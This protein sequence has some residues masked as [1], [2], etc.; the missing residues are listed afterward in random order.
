MLLHE[1]VQSVASKDDLAGFVRALRID[2]EQN[3]AQWEN[4]SL[5]SFLS[6]MEGW[7]GDMEQYYLNR[8][9]EP[10]AAPGWK[11]FADILYASKSYE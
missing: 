8:G 11:T 5:N 2:L 4:S 1:Q 6:A 9:E 7:I 10:P 3:A